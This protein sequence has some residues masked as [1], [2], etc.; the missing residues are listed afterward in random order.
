VCRARSGILI[1][2]TQGHERCTCGNLLIM[3]KTI[4]GR[5]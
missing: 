3:F 1:G 4:W 5:L 2:H